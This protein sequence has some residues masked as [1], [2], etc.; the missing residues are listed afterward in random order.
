MAE[1]VMVLHRKLFAIAAA[2]AAA[3]HGDGVY[4]SKAV[5]VSHLYSLWHGKTG[6]NWNGRV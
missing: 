6:L 1:S 2:G 3:D 5:A 4:E